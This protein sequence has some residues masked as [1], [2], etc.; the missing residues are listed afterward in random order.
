MIV[1]HQKTE[2]RK[3][4]LGYDLKY[5][6]SNMRMETYLAP[7]Y[8]QLK[9]RHPKLYYEEFIE[10]LVKVRAQAREEARKRA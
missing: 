3:I 8:A 4:A 2:I 1:A 9:K 10:E 5:K 6:I 7:A